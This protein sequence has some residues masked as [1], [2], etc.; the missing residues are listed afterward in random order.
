MQMTRLL[1]P[2]KNYFVSI[3]LSVLLAFGCAPTQFAY[4]EGESSEQAQSLPKEQ[5]EQLV[6]PIALYPDS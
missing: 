1:L 2:K 4:A 3:T 6:A 5:L